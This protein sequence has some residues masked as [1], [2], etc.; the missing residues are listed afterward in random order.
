MRIKQ[1]NV[2]LFVYIRPHVK[3]QI[4]VANTLKKTNKYNPIILF[5]ENYTSIEEDIFLLNESHI[6]YLCMNDFILSHHQVESY[7]ANISE[8]GTDNRSIPKFVSKNLGHIGRKTRA[9]INHTRKVINN[10]FSNMQKNIFRTT[11]LFINKSLL[12]RF[13]VFT[14]LCKLIS[15]STQGQLF[16]RT[17]IIKLS[18]TTALKK[19]LSKSTLH[20]RSQ[21]Y[22]RAIKEFIN[23]YQIKLLIFPENNIFYL[24]HYKIH[25]ARE[26]KVPSIIVPFT[27]ANMKEWCESLYT[28]PHYQLKFSNLNYFFGTIFKQWAMTY[29]G[30]KMI[31]PPNLILLYESLNLT[32][33]NPW[34]INDGTIDFIA[35]ESEK[36]KIYYES[37]GINKNKLLPTGA[38]YNDELNYYL[39]NLEEHKNNVFKRLGIST[40]KPVIVVA[41]PP[42]QMDS[43]IDFTE[44]ES[45]HE[46]MAFWL[47]NLSRLAEKYHIIISLHPRITPEQAGVIEQ[48][49][50]SIYP[51]QVS[52]II[53][54][55]ELYI[56]SCSATVRMAIASAKPVLNYDFYDYQYDDYKDI[57]GV[58]T[59]S[60]KDDF[61]QQ[62]NEITGN[63]SYYQRIADY[64]KEESL[65]WNNPEWN[66]S[67]NIINA[68]DN[69]LAQQDSLTGRKSPANRE[70]VCL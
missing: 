12:I 64:Q 36:M 55:S 66:A 57:K 2:L 8:S 16:F 42:N 9:A 63:P 32:P 67:D 22:E 48:Y 30:K 24:T 25:M 28:I 45:Y 58:I 39:S 59:V 14:P 70:E 15:Y 61:I 10:V 50:V 19:I 56:A 27:I 35:V 17:I 54:L 38:L 49:P 65:L 51:D 11:L 23:Q 60:K 31:L 33:Q 34:L 69:L 13:T 20:E 53:P 62:L 37:A 29:K 7:A 41:L 40:D 4:R 5:C 47:E 52:H 18:Q 21:L 1:K 3:E 43:R 44:F 46:A 6:Q 26:Y 68:I